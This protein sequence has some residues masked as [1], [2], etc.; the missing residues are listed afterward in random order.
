M[1]KEEDIA[2]YVL[3]S[4]CFK[5]DGVTAAFEMHSASSEAPVLLFYCFQQPLQILGSFICQQD[6][7]MSMRKR[8]DLL[9]LRQHSK[10][11][12]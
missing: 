3:S 10:V 6:L 9:A 8:S 4:L 2:E 11:H 12:L 5:L 1:K 7:R